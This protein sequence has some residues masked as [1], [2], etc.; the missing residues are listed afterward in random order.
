MNQLKNWII[1]RFGPACLAGVTA[2]D[3]ARLCVDNGFRFS[4]RYWGKVPYLTVSSLLTS[5]FATAESLVHGRSIRET[6][7]QAP[8]FIVGSW[9]SGTTFLHTLMCLDERFGCPNLFQTMYPHS[10]LV[11]EPWLRPML[12][13]GTP[14]KRFMDNMAMNLSEPHEDEMA[15]AILSRRSNMLSWA[16]PHRADNYDRFLDFKDTTK[17]DRDAWKK[18][19]DYFVRKMTYK[20]DGKQLVLKSPNHTARIKMLLELYPNA[21]FLHIYRNPYHVFRSMVHMATAVTQVWGLQYFPLEDIPAMVVDTYKRL[22][23]A[24][25][26]QVDAIPSG[27]LIEVRYEDFSSSPVE[28]LAHVYEELNLP[29]FSATRPN[30]EAHVAARSS[31]KKNKHSETAPD[32]LAMIN[33]QWSAMFERFGYQLTR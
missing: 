25:F 7:P 26:E 15:L 16:F 2:G 6:E 9:R 21:K 12:E 4:P 31:Y 17:A 28:T 22:Y 14:T 23:E 11:S 5:G 13:L 1:N 24:Y 30:I 32:H 20:T 33:E 3:W 19:F 27:Q 29:D 18:A 8:V 10:F